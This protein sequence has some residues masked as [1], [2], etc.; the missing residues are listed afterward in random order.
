MKNIS[1]ELQQLYNDYRHAEFVWGAHDCVI[2]AARWADLKLHTQYEADVRQRFQYKTIRQA[3]KII[4]DS[5]GLE[6]MVS[7]YLGAP[8]PWGILPQGSIVLSYTSD[9]KHEMLTILGPS[10]LVAPGVRGIRAM[11]IDFA[12]KGWDLCRRSL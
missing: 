5:G 3:L 6:L 1:L 10:Q 8:K 9:L 7:E 4:K 11:P 2:F 12:I